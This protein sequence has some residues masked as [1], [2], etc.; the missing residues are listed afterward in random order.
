MT[1]IMPS[2]YFWLSTVQYT[3]WILLM[4]VINWYV[5][6]T[7]IHIYK[8]I[9]IYI[10]IHRHLLYQNATVTYIMPHLPAG[11]LVVWQL[12]HLRCKP[13]EESAKKRDI[14]ILSSCAES[15]FM[16]AIYLPSTGTSLLAR[17]GSEPCYFGESVCSFAVPCF[18]SGCIPTPE[19]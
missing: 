2:L 9:Y 19:E 3:H 10:Y 12:S 17:S 18:N 14:I 1:N 6:H 8:Y 15:S 4:K 7:Y 13:G 5:Y 11:F 16:F